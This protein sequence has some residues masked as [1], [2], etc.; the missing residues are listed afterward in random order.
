[1]YHDWEIK[2]DNLDFGGSVKRG[3]P[4]IYRD[5]GV[6]LPYGVAKPLSADHYILVGFG[7]DLQRHHDQPFPY[8]ATNGTKSFGDM[9][10]RSDGGL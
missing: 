4:A 5:P 9:I 10:Y 7:P 8:S 1:M 3:V 6:G 2:D